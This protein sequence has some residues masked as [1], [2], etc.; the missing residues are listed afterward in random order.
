MLLS[1]S[2]PS[3]LNSTLK[4][5]PTYLPLPEVAKKYGLSEQALTQL[6]QTGKI[7]AVRLPSGELLVPANNDTKKIKTKEQII[8][9]KFGDLREHPIAVSE[10]SKKYEVL[11]RT[12]RE[13]ISLDYIQIVDDNYPMKIDEAE[14]AYCAEIF[15]ERKAAGI[16]SGAP[17][18]DENGL[19]YK[20]KHPELSAYRRRKR[21]EKQKMV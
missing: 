21:H 5:I 6:I 11:G 9:E 16:R 15:H 2:S 20:L 3:T 18:L 7:E 17:L 4:N 12:I 1:N 14:M 8:G 19:P 10:A 13:W